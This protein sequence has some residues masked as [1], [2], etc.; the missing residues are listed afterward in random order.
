MKTLFKL[1][2]VIIITS[3]ILSC[4]KDKNDDNNNPVPYAWAC[5]EPDSTGYGMIL[6]S[7]D[8]GDNWVR[9]GIG[10][11]ALR[12]IMLQDIWAIDENNVWA[13]GSNKIIRTINGGQTWTSV[14]V[15]FDVTGRDLCSISIFNKTNIWI[16]G[17]NGTVYNSNDNGNSWTMCDTTFFNHASLHGINA[18]SQNKIFVTGGIGAI[19]NLRGYSAY[20]LDGGTTWDSIVPANN[21][22]EHEWI[23]VCSSGNTT[24]VYGTRANY[25]VSTDGGT[26]W[27]NGY[28]PKTGGTKG[29]DINHLIMLDS[30]TWWGAFDMGAIFITLDGGANWTRQPTVG[31]SQYFMLGIDAWDSQL[32]IAVGVRAGVLNNCPIIKTRNGGALWEQKYTTSNSSLFKVT[33]IK[34]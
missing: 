3:L 20:T 9:Q 23:G 31:L 32:A 33:F 14:Q 2:F 15:P 10:S 1:T 7:A 22:N 17:S 6:F 16:S 29:A 13:V 19:G 18:I 11:T 27:T 12:E 34:D 28:I 30:Q 8:G 4:K 21:Y 5:G 25:I 24:V 26:T